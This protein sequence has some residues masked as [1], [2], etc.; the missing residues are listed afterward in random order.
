MPTLALTL[1]CE[2]KHGTRTH[3][4]HEQL[5]TFGTKCIDTLLAEMQVHHPWDYLVAV[6][7]LKQ[8]RVPVDYVRA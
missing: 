8:M 6:L 4:Q 5:Q 3:L 7:E 1:D 2:W